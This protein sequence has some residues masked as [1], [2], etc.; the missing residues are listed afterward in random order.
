MLE[1]YKGYIVYGPY[2]RRDKR[3]VVV[4]YNQKERITISYP[5]FLMENHLGRRLKANE[6]V[7]HKDKNVENNVLDNLEVI[8][9]IEHL[10]F[11][12]PTRSA[13]RVTLICPVCK[14]EFERKQSDIDRYHRH[15]NRV[16]KMYC[17]KE[18]NGVDNH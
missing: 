6:E 8:D 10:E 4:L 2:T 15:H 1:E 18:C 11:H 3:Q 9:Y 12:G 16:G 13:K 7:H 17:S 14:E 5:K